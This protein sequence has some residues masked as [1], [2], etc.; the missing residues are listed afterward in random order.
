MSAITS[1]MA[2]PKRLPSE[3]IPT[4]RKNTLAQKAH[5]WNGAKEK[6]KI[7]LLLLKWQKRNALFS[8]IPTFGSYHTHTPT[9][10][11]ATPL[12]HRKQY[13]LFIEPS[14]PSAN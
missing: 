2:P 7:L 8:P 10:I 9:C 14:L 5:Q 13:T 11:Y 6:S 12:H 3:P 4:K 1:G